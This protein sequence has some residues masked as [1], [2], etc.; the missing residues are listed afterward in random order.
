MSKKERE[1]IIRATF[2]THELE[3]FEYTEEER[4]FFQQYIDGKKTL[5]ELYA[6]INRKFKS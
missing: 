6:E 1:R 2:H 4:A 3:G 5:E